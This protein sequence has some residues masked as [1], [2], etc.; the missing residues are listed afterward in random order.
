MGTGSAGGGNDV[1]VKLIPTVVK[2]GRG[3]VG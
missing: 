2:V 3:T 1:T